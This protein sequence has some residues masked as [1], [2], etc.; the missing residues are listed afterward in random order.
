MTIQPEYNSTP[1]QRGMAAAITEFSNLEPLIGD[2]NDPQELDLSL[3]PYK[4]MQLGCLAWSVHFG[5]QYQRD[6]VDASHQLNA[7]AGSTAALNI[8][9]RLHGVNHNPNYSNVS[10][11]VAR[12]ID[13]TL[14]SQ[15]AYNTQQLEELK[16]I[17]GAYLPLWLAITISIVR[18]VE[19]GVRVGNYT[20]SRQ[21]ITVSG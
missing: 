6:A 9:D 7:L 5:D 19:T 14:I 2:W 13:L 3:M 10:G 20:Y 11:G 18:P 16:R 21:E 12:T 8:L 1:Y 17:Y 15:I 4:A